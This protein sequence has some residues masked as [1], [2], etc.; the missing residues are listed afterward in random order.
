M[1]SKIILETQSKNANNR[2]LAIVAIGLL[3]SLEM[4]HVQINE[5]HA[6]LFHPYSVDKLKEAKAD[7]KLVNIW[8]RALFLEDLEAHFPEEV[9]KKRISEFKEELFQFLDTLKWDLFIERKWITL[10]EM[11]MSADE[12]IND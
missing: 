8:H 6:Y 4:E 9:L 5:V 3:H 1:P 2:M 7:P 10:K 11:K 12:K